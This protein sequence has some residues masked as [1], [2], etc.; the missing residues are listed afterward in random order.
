MPRPVLLFDGDCGFCTRSAELLRGLRVNADVVA[1][2]HHD[3]ARHGITPADAMAAVQF[4]DAD[5]RVASGHHAVTGVLRT[6]GRFWRLIAR[7]LEAPGLTQL[8]ARTYRVV[9]KYRYRLPG[10]TPACAMKPTD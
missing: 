10:G 7:S 5:G 6:G 1:W 4:V 3:I 9:A 8:A 2:Q